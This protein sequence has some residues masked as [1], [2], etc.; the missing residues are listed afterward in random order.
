MEIIWTPPAIRDLRRIHRQTAERIR[1][2][3]RRYATTQLGDVRK[4]E[5][6]QDRYRL[7]VGEHRVIFRYERGRLVIV[8][9]RVGHRRDAYRS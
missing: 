8:V 7:R 3:V 6:E 9:L 4:L 5:G 1:E 2:A